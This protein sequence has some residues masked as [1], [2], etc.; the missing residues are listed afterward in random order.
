MVRFGY[1]KSA[2]LRIFN[3]V[4]T[5][6]DPFRTPLAAIPLFAQYSSFILPIRHRKTS[7]NFW[8]K[9]ETQIEATA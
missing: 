9:K 6:S 8:C 5:F 4:S 2:F 3:T 1:E 7:E